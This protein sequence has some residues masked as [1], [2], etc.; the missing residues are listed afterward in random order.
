MHKSLSRVKKGYDFMS[1]PGAERN[2][3]KFVLDRLPDAG[4]LERMEENVISLCVNWINNPKKIQIIPDCSGWPLASQTLHRQIWKFR[5]RRPLPVSACPRRHQRA[6]ADTLRRRTVR[7]HGLP[8]RCK[9][10]KGAGSLRGGP[11]TVLRVLGLVGS[12]P[13]LL[14]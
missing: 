3:R 2:A 13:S 12:Q 10:G 11:G 14:E 6:V 1:L 8:K 5:G 4:L 9:R 7:Q